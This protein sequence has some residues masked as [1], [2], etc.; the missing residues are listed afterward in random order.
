MS[1]LRQEAFKLLETAPEENLFAVIQLLQTKKKLTADENS[2][3]DNTQETEHCHAR[4]VLFR[5]GKS[6]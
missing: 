4:A 2:T 5:V 6:F 3:D 1:P